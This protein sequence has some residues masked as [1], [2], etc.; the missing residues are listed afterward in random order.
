V[1]SPTNQLKAQLVAVERLA[2][3]AR[4]LKGIISGGYS[5]GMGPY[6]RM[7]ERRDT[8]GISEKGVIDNDK[9]DH[10]LRSPCDIQINEIRN[11]CQCKCHD[12]TSGHENKSSTPSINKVPS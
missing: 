5:Q 4:M 1:I 6:M 12:Y 8:P 2:P 11:R 10:H 9:E 7:S 3:L